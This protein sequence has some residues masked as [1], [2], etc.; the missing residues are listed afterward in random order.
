MATC[1]PEHG[2]KCLNDFLFESWFGKEGLVCLQ[3]N[4]AR[5]FEKGHVEETLISLLNNL[6]FL[7]AD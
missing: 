4:A 2:G 1:L 7:A 5:V 3:E 6:A